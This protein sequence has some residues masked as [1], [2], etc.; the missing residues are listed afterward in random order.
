MSKKYQYLARQR[1]SYAHFEATT[2]CKYGRSGG[3][4]DCH[5]CLNRTGRTRRL[6]KLN[7]NKQSN[8]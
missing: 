6:Q 2:T 5:I 1:G 7:Q 4:T 8:Q 3:F